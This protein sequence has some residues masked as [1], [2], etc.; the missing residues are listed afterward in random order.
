[1]H[2]LR[3]NLANEQGSANG[4]WVETNLLVIYIPINTLKNKANSKLNKYTFCNLT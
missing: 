1:M 4:G 2:S 3:N